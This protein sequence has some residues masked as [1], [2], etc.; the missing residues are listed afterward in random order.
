MLRLVPLLLLVI[1]IA[2][3]PE[4][5]AQPTA[6]DALRGGG[7][8]VM[9]AVQRHYPT[10]H[11]RIMEALGRHA[12]EH[13]DDIAGRAALTRRMLLDFF[14]HRAAGLA[15]APGPLVTDIVG[16]HRLLLR[17]LAKDDTALCADLAT[18]FL[19]GRFDLP[20]FYQDRAT[21]LSVS[22]VEAARE[23][24]K[25]PPETARS[26]L[27]AEDAMR[28]YEELLR[29]VP[30]S[31][32]QAAIAAD[33]AAASGSPAMQCRVGAAIFG[34]MENLGPEQAANVG[35]FFLA[36]TLAEPGRE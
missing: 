7:R 11:A 36:Q 25:S 4:S 27:A 8:E 3:A 20:A 22:I 26:G 32:I 30:S 35:A 17:L 23:G 2:A 12:A 28:W 33:S 15:N 31:D 13:P 24:E 16:R 21:A 5:R 18:N 9:N 34:A 10:D 1:A 19:I 29:V 6:G 14:R